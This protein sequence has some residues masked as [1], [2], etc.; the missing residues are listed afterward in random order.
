VASESL[1]KL[2]RAEGEWEDKIESLY[3]AVSLQAQ[4]VF[5]T[6]LTMSFVSVQMFGSRPSLANM[7]IERWNMPI[8]L[9]SN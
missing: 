1:I 5:N 6:F 9:G 2:G 3:A 7:L 4:A 8:E